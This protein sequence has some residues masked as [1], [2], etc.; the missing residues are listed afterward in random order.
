MGLNFQKCKTGIVTACLVCMPAFVLLYPRSIVTSAPTGSDSSGNLL[1]EIKDY[2]NWTK[3]NSTP[4]LMLGRVAADCAIQLSPTG[5]DVDGTRNPHLNKY[6]TVYVNEVGRKAMLDQKH[7][8][9]PAGSVIVKEKLSARDSQKPELLTVMIKQQKGFNPE[10]GDWEY[11]VVDGSGTKMAGRG[12]L[13][14]CQ[15]CHVA[16][17]HTDYVFRTYLPDGVASKLK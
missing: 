10:S 7:P 9:F 8:Q 3:V 2:R 14:N 15:S 13:Q 12:N 1:K 4:Q 6:F 17:P 16:R 11:M 5:I